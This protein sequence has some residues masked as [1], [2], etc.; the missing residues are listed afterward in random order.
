MLR[1]MPNRVVVVLGISALL[2]VHAAG[3]EFLLPDTSGL[4]EAI[5]RQ[6]VRPMLRLSDDAPVDHLYRWLKLDVDRDGYDELFIRL[7]GPGLCARGDC[8]IV[9]FRRIED[10]S[11]LPIIT[12]VGSTVAM[13]GEPVLVT[14]TGGTQAYEYDPETITLVPSN[15]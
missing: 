9:G 2:T 1:Q 5:G 4:S 6:F 12:A 3:A 13:E 14:G 11:W 7:E 8:P 15:R 10:G